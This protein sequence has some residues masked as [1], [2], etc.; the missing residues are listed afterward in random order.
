MKPKLTGDVQALPLGSQV[1]T[2]IQGRPVVTSTPPVGSSYIWSGV[3]WV[4]G[5]RIAYGTNTNSVSTA[6]TTFAAGADLLATP[7][8]FTATGSNSYILSVFAPAWFNTG[9]FLNVL[10][11][12]VDG[13]DN[14]LFCY[15]NLFAN[16]NA[17]LADATIFTPSAGNHTVNVKLVVTG[18]TGT[19]SVTSRPILVTLE[20][21]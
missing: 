6:G 21:A 3:A 19:I 11:L 8:K 16:T 13:V 10:H 15:A 12:N 18:G 5:G 17:P 2:A 20:T 7:L 14:D 9:A 4:P 1:V